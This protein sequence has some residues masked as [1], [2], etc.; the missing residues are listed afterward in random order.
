MTAGDVWHWAREAPAERL[1][2]PASCGMWTAGEILH[3]ASVSGTYMGFGSAAFAAILYGAGRGGTHARQLAVTALLSG[4][5]LTAAAEIGPLAGHYCPLSIAWLAGTLIGYRLL[6][7][8]DVIRAKREWRKAKAAWLD[9]GP[10]YGL[11]NSHLLDWEQ[12]RLGEAMVVDVSGTGKRASSLIAGSLAEDIAQH[13]KLAVNRV[14]VTTAGIAGRIRISKRYIDPWKY[15]IPHPL[16]DGDP[17]LDLPVPATIRGPLIVGQDPES[18]KPLTITLWDGDGAK[19]AFL[20]GIKGAG[21]T[22]LLNCVRERLTAAADAVVFDINVWK[23]RE[24]RDWA[25]ACDLT[26]IGAENRKRALVIL[27]CANAA[28]LY[29][30]AQP[31]DTSAFQPSASQPLIVVM[32]DEVDKL[33]KGNDYLAQGIRSELGKLVSA[34]RSEGVA[35]IMAGQRGTADWMGGSDTR[36]QIDVFCVGKV[37]RRGEMHHAAGDMGLMMPDMASYG[38]GHAGVWVIAELGGSCEAGRTFYLTEPPDLRRL[39]SERASTQPPLEP[40][41]VEHLGKAYATLK[42]RETVTASAP[43]ATGATSAPTPSS[44][45]LRQFGQ[46]ILAAADAGELGGDWADQVEAFRAAEEIEQRRERESIDALDAEVEETLP[47]DLRHTLRTIAE[48]SAETRQLLADADAIRLPDVDP[49]KLAA[50]RQ[51][52]WDQVAAV[53]EVPAEAREKL[54]GL[55]AAGT[56]IRPAATALGVSVWTMRRWLERLRSEGVAWLD[57]EKRAARWRLTEHPEA[58][59]SGDSQ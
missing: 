54:L 42:G 9:E 10:R 50:A 55:L 59:E 13:E 45:P 7:G 37:G 43:G 1:S 26:A 12:T 57:G 20:V 58:S 11:A 53:S 48:R 30:S 40:G 41:L 4:A 17:E 8:H 28:V 32:I 34:G 56:T 21:K 51:E 18:G 39:A 29:R 24:D 15:P 23:A 25:P 49:A 47:D 19:N 6:R 5:W 44:N 35:V 16:L 3:A 2:I 31:R 36:S 38:E 33:V 52:R 22:A 27:R 14:R 46:T